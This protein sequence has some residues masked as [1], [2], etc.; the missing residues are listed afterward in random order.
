MSIMDSSVIELLRDQERFEDEVAKRLSSLLDRVDNHVVKLLLHTLVLD[1]MK[2]ASIIRALLDLVQGTS[3]SEPDK[4]L[5]REELSRHISE[6]EEMLVKAKEL[7]G[8]VKDENVKAVLEQITL[9]E[10]RHHNGLRQLLSVLDKVESIGD[11][12][13][14]EFMNEWANFS[15]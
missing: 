9:E 12:E 10:E 1:S 4:R 6:E 11:E 5:L 7:A 14:W 13:W 15:T 2:H 3:L 8:K